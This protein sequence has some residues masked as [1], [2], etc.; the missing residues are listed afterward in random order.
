MI[1][2]EV[3]G[4]IDAAGTLQT[5]YMSNARLVTE[6]TDTPANIAFDPTLLDPG[7]LS[8]QVFSDG[9][10]TGGTQL[11]TGEIVITNADGRYDSWL[12]YGFD[13]R[14]VVIRSGVAGTAY[15]SAWITLFTGTV[16]NISA[17]K[18]RM[19]IRLK[20][21]QHIFELP[22][23]SNRYGGTN[24]LPNGVDGVPGD[25]K[26]T[27]KPITLGKV[28]YVAPPCVN[29]SKL[30]YQVCDG[31][32]QS[33]A[34]VYDLGATL[35]FSA[36]YADPT[37]LLAA[38]LSTGYATCKAYGLIRLG[39][40][41]Q[42]QVTCDLTG[43]YRTNL[44]NYSTNP[45]TG[46][47]W[48]DSSSTSSSGGTD[49]IF[50]KS[51]V[52]SGGAT[53][54]RRVCSGFSLVGGV[55]YALTFYFKL[56]TSGQIYAAL[57]MDGTH[58]IDMWGTPTNMSTASGSGTGF[59][60]N[61][62]AKVGLRNDGVYVLTATVT[63]TTSGTYTWGAGPNSNTTGQ[64]VQL[65]GAQ[66]EAGPWPSQSIT[67]TSAAASSTLQTTSTVVAHMA[68]MAG[69]DLWDLDDASI[70][71][72]ETANNAVVGIYLDDERTFL[73]AM[74]EVSRSVGAWYGFTPDGDFT[75]NI[76][77]APSGTPIMTLTEYYAGKDYE[78]IPARDNVSPVWSVKVGYQKVWTPQ[79]YV[80]G[81]VSAAQRQFVLQ[82]YRSASVVD[83]AVKTQYLLATTLE[84]N[85]L[86]TTESAASAE[87][88]R[89]SN[90][91]KVHRDSFEI[92]LPLQVIAQASLRLGGVVNLQLARFGLSG[93]K[94]MRVQSISLNLATARATLIVWG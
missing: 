2:I 71:A 1:A 50:T 11:S 19:L 74:D 69:V 67:T 47:G 35:T 53:W 27:V 76:W 37:A 87:A 70:R 93:G 79:D 61:K 88:T 80:V 13:G 66:V 3:V 9:K 75:M 20:D 40:L 55:T 94:L 48:S 30:V 15:P 18:N 5:F 23:L 34:A 49:G 77:A 46:T 51:I 12:N 17:E 31:P 56:G 24:S 65:L 84:M 43:T 63:P 25:I 57:Y 90:L 44:V 89:L 42:G 21:R 33:I 16:D 32:V 62:V 6:A 73:D 28:F 36:D 52:A 7:S 45:A 81:T 41:P 60:V 54:N 14:P 58:F 85:T 91:H 29:T 22:S 72:V 92:P 86:L 4:A 78:R 38:S 83:A 64:T 39:A 68:L 10:T 59:T 8:V 82:E 26:G